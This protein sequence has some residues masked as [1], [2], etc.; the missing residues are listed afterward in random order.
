MTKTLG[1]FIAA[2]LVVSLASCTTPPQTPAPKQPAT[3]TPAPAPVSVK[4]NRVAIALTTDVT[5]FDPGWATVTNDNIQHFFLMDNLLFRTPE[6]DLIPWLAVAYKAISQTEWEF[7]LREGVKFHNGEVFDGNAVKHSFDRLFRADD[8][9][10]ARARYNTIKEIRVVSPYTTRIITENPDPLLPARISMLPIVPPKYHNERGRSHFS[11]NPVGTGPYKFKEWVKDSRI[12]LEANPDY[13]KGKPKVDTIIFRPIPEYSTRL[14]LLRTGEVDLITH[15]IPDDAAKLK[16]TPGIKVHVTPILRT[17][18]LLMRPDLRP[19]DNKLVR[20]AINYAINKESIV[21]DILG[22]YGEVAKAQV[23]GPMYFGYNPNLKPY[24]YDP[25]KARELLAQAGYKDGF[26]LTFYTPAG[27]YTL[28][29]EIAEAIS[30]QLRQVGIRVSLQPM[31]WGVYAQKQQDKAF[32]HLNL[33]A[34]MNTMYD[35][36]G[37]LQGLFR[38]GVIWG[39]GPYWSNKRIDD[40]IDQARAT[41]DQNVR[42]KLYHEAA[43]ILR[44][45]AP[46]VFL[47]H[48]TEI[49]A[50]R[51][52][53]N[54]IARPDEVPDVFGKQHLTR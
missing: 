13:W 33:F 49:Y 1:L 27:R 2:L 26:E 50:V 23:I 25:A 6:G 28:D 39:V 20:Q 34:F 54:F 30:A 42:L 51:E 40:I 52:G 10:P 16:T 45:E 36:D 21:K 46:V 41:V 38:S 11:A 7:T 35:A 4:E 48:L 32:A 29:K 14:A 8:P 44:D 24:P 43:E 19:L 17:M 12:V 15:V 5:T 3:P 47:H 37:V 22:G 53:V 18:E 31:E 9:S